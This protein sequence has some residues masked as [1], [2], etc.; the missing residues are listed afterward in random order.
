MVSLDM[1]FFSAISFA[2][3]LLLAFYSPALAQETEVLTG[4]GV[5]ISLPIVDENIKDGSIIASTDSG[6]KKSSY[7]YQPSLYGVMTN[8]PALFLEN[9]DPPP[10]DTYHPVITTGKAYVLVSTINGSIKKNDFITSSETPGVG[11]KSSA[12]GYVLGTALEDYTSSDTRSEGRILAYINP[13][14]N[15]TFI[16]TRANL[17]ES[18]RNIAASPTLAPLTTFRYIIAALIATASFILGFIHFGRIIRTGI[19]ALGRNPLASVFI[20]ASMLL[21]VALTI[22]VVLGGIAISYLVLV[23]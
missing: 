11:Q 20:Q 13:H 17:L 14:F 22:G 3:I 10:K 8:T 5:A 9:G 4:T 21:N 18:L 23:L 1:R 15:A 7:A 2:L 16:A 19:E 12:S 6:Y